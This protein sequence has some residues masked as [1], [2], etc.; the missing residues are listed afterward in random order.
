M[1]A[2]PAPASSPALPSPAD[3]LQTAGGHTSAV[4]GHAGVCFVTATMG[5]VFQAGRAVRTPCFLAVLLTRPA[6]TDGAH[7]SLPSPA[8]CSL[9]SSKWA[10][11]SQHPD[12]LHIGQP[13]SGGRQHGPRR[14]K[15]GP[16]RP[17]V[18]GYT[19]SEPCAGSSPQS[20]VPP[21]ALQWGA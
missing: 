6:G 3:G 2:C 15:T 4:R 9:P 19:L 14:P 13:R 17:A 5:H 8:H 12:L 10:E 11:S 20:Q 16:R 7:L 21:K 18:V 1:R